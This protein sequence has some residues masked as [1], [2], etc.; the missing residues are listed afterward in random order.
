MFE[1]SFNLLARD[2]WKPEQEIVETGPVFQILKE[3]FD[4]HASSPEHPR[5]TDF[6]R[7]ALNGRT[8]RPIQHGVEV[9]G[10]VGKGQA[11]TD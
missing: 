2:A 4:R 8:R 9:N 11:R 5:T 3:C 1:H 6:T 10:K 7:Y